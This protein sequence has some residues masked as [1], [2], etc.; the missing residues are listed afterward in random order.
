MFEYIE[1]FFGSDISG[2][3]FAVWGLS[4]KP[5]TDDMRE[6]PSLVLMDALLAAG[7]V[8]RAHDPEAMVEAEHI[9]KAEANREEKK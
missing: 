7:A 5:N 9:Y 1:S 8:V 6:A 2:K 4:F 3:T